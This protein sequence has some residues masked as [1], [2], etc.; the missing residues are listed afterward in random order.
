MS[1]G[2]SAVGSDVD[3][4]GVDTPPG[5][6]T[7]ERFKHSLERARR[8]S[9]SRR[10]VSRHGGS[11]GRSFMSVAS[12]AHGVDELRDRRK[13][14]VFI[15]VVSS[16]CVVTFVFAVNVLGFIT[17]D[18][19]SNRSVT[20]HR[21]TTAAIKINLDNIVTVDKY[22]YSSAVLRSCE[23]DASDPSMKSVETG[24]PR[25]AMVPSTMSLDGLPKVTTSAGVAAAS[26]PELP[27]LKSSFSLPRTG[28]IPL[29]R[30]V[31]PSPLSNIVQEQSPSES[32][33]TSVPP[34]PRGLPKFG[35][36][37]LGHSLPRGTIHGADETPAKLPTA[38]RTLPSAY[39]NSSVTS[40]AGRPPPFAVPTSSI[41]SSINSVASTGSRRPRSYSSDSA[42]ARASGSR[43]RIP[44]PPSVGVRTLNRNRDTPLRT[45]I[46][47]RAVASGMPSRSGS[48]STYA[49][50]TTAA[51]TGASTPDHSAGPSTAHGSRADLPH[52]DA[53]VDDV[54]KPPRG[55]LRDG[56]GLNMPPRLGTMTLGRIPASPVAPPRRFAP[57]PAD[58]LPLSDTVT[59]SV[60]LPGAHSPERPADA[61][62]PL[63]SG[64]SFGI[65]PV[66]D[67]AVPLEIRYS[68]L[69]V[70]PPPPPP[71]LPSDDLEPA[72]AAATNDD[73]RA[74][75]LLNRTRLISGSSDGPVPLAP[76]SS[77]SSWAN[78]SLRGGVSSLLRS[79]RDISSELRRSASRGSPTGGGGGGGSSGG[80]SDG[81]EKKQDSPAALV[82]AAGLDA[83]DDGGDD[84]MYPLRGLT[85]SARTGSR[86]AGLAEEV[87]AE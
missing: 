67:V 35:H 79:L 62:M 55:G 83:A 57:V 19:I 8:P 25:G 64:E 26:S 63:M 73:E 71:S 10:T 20:S 75:F 42:R 68:S 5:G 43:D 11:R 70:I 32:L 16:V 27:G 51:G 49:G 6:R 60:T 23:L 86:N 38:V 74:S 54:V 21:Q 30:P 48:T 76:W 46:L 72:T 33:S 34:S 15:L 56:A 59:S 87:V 61:S 58:T 17:L 66:P 9:A 37:R 2:N 69:P 40:D 22:M 85:L 44:P 31:S 1:R 36:D 18:R 45:R 80:M 52:A 7:L 82:P 50:G 28:R 77:E 12:I 3:V 53:S 47:Q 84:V 81:S 14:A 13:L 65:L 4:P 78:G 29:P 41:T 24:Q 39:S